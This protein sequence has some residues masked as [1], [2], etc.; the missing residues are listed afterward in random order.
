MTQAPTPEDADESPFAPQRKPV[1]AGSGHSYTL[2]SLL[3]I[4]TGIGVTAVVSFAAIAWSLRGL[5]RSSPRALLA[6]VLES[7]A[8]RAGRARVLAVGHSTRPAAELVE[9]LLAAGVVTL[10][11]VRTIPRSRANPQVEGPALARTV[12]AAGIRY[13]HLPAL[14]G[15]RHARKG[16]PNGAW[17]NASFRGYADHMQTP[18]FEEGLCQLR[19]LAKAGPVALLCAEADADKFSEMIL[20]GTSAFGVRRHSAERRKL[21]REFTKVKTPFGDV[22]VKLGK[23]NGEIVQAAPEF[24]SCRKVADKAGAPLKQVYETAM[25]ALKRRAKLPREIRSQR[26]VLDW[27]RARTASRG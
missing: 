20:R 24:E 11:D 14:G 2:G 25:R 4:M 18:E 3:L 13:A 10:A 21:K 6:G 22:T 5:A 26:E 27:R 7:R 23:L 16:S 9:L 8:T 15:L 17:R 1:Y 12:A 19:A